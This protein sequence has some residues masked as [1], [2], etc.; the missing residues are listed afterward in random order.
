MYIYNIPT[1]IH[2][3]RI[4]REKKLKLKRFIATIYYSRIMLISRSRIRIRVVDLFSFILHF[5]ADLLLLRFL[6]LHGN[7]SCFAINIPQILSSGGRLFKI[8]VGLGSVGVLSLLR[9]HWRR[10][11]TRTRIV[12]IGR[13]K[14][15]TEGQPLVRLLEIK[16]FNALINSIKRLN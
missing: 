12:E 10:W 13:K 6:Y 11:R 8:A 14:S 4:L 2:S 16:I 7:A 5:D 9:S 3:K 1:K 15:N